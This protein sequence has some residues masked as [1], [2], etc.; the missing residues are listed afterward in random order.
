MGEWKGARMSFRNRS[1]D[2]DPLGETIAGE[3]L[4]CSVQSKLFRV[5]GGDLSADD[6]LP[7]DLLNDEI[8]YPAVRELTNLRFNPLHQARIGVRTIQLHGVSLKEMRNKKANWKSDSPRVAFSCCPSHAIDCHR[9]RKQLAVCF[10]R[11]IDRGSCC[12]G[13]VS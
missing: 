3:Q 11:R 2:R 6:H 7:L 13:R 4:E 10:R 5:P 8:A 9:K 1:A 12:T